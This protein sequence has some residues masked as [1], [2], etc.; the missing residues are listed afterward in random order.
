[1]IDITLSE[2]K[3]NED[4]LLD[5][6]NDELFKQKK[7]NIIMNDR[8]LLALQ[9]NLLMMGFDLNMINK[10]IMYFNIRTINEAID[11]L[12]KSDEGMWR[13]PFV[14]SQEENLKENEP[15]LNN[16]ILDNVITRVKTLNFDKSSKNLCEICGESKEFHIINNI[17][18]VQIGNNILDFDLDNNNLLLNDNSNYSI[19]NINN[20]N[21]KE[22]EIIN[23]KEDDDK[24]KNECLICLDKLENPVVIERCKH[25]FCHDCFEDYLNNLINQNNIDKIP[26]PNKACN[27][28]SLSPD[29]FSNYLSQEQLIKYNQFKS[30]NEIA[31]D[32]CKIFCPLCDSYAKIDNPE[33]YDTNNDSYKKSKLICQKGH[34]FCSCGRP[35]HEGECYHDTDEFRNLITKEKIK[36]CPKCGFLIKKNNGCNH[37]T[38][39]NKACKYEFCWLCLQE[40]LPGH[41]ETGPCSGKQFIDP[42]SIFYQLEQKYP[43]L[44]YVFTFFKIIFCLIIFSLT[45]CFPVSALWFLYGFFLH[46]NYNMDDNDADKLYVLPKCL[47]IWHFI[48]GIPILFATQSLYYFG[49]AIGLIVLATYLWRLFI[50]S[51]CVCLLNLYN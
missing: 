29:F 43:F 10:V 42:D 2:N 6:N 11:Y 8:E 30:K 17:S 4:I 37:M 36:K 51:F 7:K 14:E 47:T 18:N 49:L 46:E 15:G 44:F 45:L 28:K 27:N 26:C 12:S 40:S 50:N 32:K 3:E 25:R 5:I 9:G 21:N 24:T 13:H 23:I 20:N 35:N 48:L 22:P 33:K 19:D 1:M 16:S 31:K 41:F 38:C 39:G 34:E